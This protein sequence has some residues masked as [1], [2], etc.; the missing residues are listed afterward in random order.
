MVSA[1]TIARIA[2]MF[3][4]PKSAR[5]NDFDVPAP[6]PRMARCGLGIAGASPG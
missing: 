5:S 6:A 4:R 2:P 3:G 1:P